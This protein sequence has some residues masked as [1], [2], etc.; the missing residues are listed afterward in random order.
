MS[1]A[2]FTVICSNPAVAQDAGAAQS[3]WY[4]YVGDHPVTSRWAVHLEG[5]WRRTP[6]LL[7]PEQRLLRTGVD[8]KLGP[9]W[10]ALGGYTYVLDTPPPG[11]TRIF[12]TESRHSIFEQ[13]GKEQTVQAFKLS[14]VVRLEQT[15]ASL[16]AEDQ[17]VT[18]SFRQRVRYHLGIEVEERSKHIPLIPAYYLIYDEIALSIHPS[19]MR[20]TLNQNRVYAAIGW[21]IG[22]F[23]KVELG[24]MH[25]FLPVSNGIVARHNDSLQITVHSIRPFGRLFSLRPRS[26]N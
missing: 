11:S 20:E 15:F 5:Q 13:I 17:S 18:W 3:G 6:F 8:R 1:F 2:I 10:T 4:I 23:E 21:K 26:A 25:Q 24:Y 19:A 16:R 7:H 9:G 14:H 12:G 22:E